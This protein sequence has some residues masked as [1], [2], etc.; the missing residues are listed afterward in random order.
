M[1]KLSSLFTKNST[2]FC[3]ICSSSDASRD[4]GRARTAWP[5]C[6]SSQ[7]RAALEAASEVP[8]EAELAA[9][10]A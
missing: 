9:G 5:H 8:P 1:P 2:V 7:P 3:L 4:T 10:D 6:N